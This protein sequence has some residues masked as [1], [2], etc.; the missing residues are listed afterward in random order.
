MSPI[1]V[2]KFRFCLMVQEMV[3]EKIHQRPPTS[4]RVQTCEVSTRYPPGASQV[5]NRNNGVPGTY[6]RLTAYDDLSPDPLSLETL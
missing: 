5:C 4:K 6:T 1:V 2:R 3:V